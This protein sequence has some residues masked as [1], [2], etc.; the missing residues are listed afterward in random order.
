MLFLLIQISYLFFS[1]GVNIAEV[2][3]SSALSSVSLE[4]NDVTSGNSRRVRRKLP[5]P[6]SEDNDNDLSE[7]E[8]KETLIR[9]IKVPSFLPSFLPSF[10]AYI[11]FN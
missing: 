1:T 4:S 8:E 3:V 11:F 10:F 9:R 2:P 6:P 7:R 5:P